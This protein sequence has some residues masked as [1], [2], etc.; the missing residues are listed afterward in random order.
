MREWGLSVFTLR[1]EPPPFIH[2]HG[3]SRC[4]RRRLTCAFAPLRALGRGRGGGDDPRRAAAARA[5]REAPPR[6]GPAGRPHP[7]PGASGR[8]KTEA[9]GEAGARARGG[10]GEDGGSYSSRWVCPPLRRRRE[11]CCVRPGAGGRP[12]GAERSGPGRRGGGGVAGGRGGSRAVG[13]PACGGRGLLLPG[14]HAGGPRGRAAAAGR[15]GGGGG[16]TRPRADPAWAGPAG[17]RAGARRTQWPLEEET[18]EARAPSRLGVHAGRGGPG[19]ETFSRGRE[20]KRLQNKAAAAAAHGAGRGPGGGAPT[21]YLR[22]GGRRGGGGSPRPPNFVRGRTAAGAGARGVAAWAPPPPRVGFVTRVGSPRAGRATSRSAARGAGPGGLGGGVEAPSA[23][24]RPGARRWRAGPARRERRPRRHVPAGRAAR[25]EGGGH[26]GDCAPRPIVPGLGLGPRATG[27]A[28]AEPPPLWAGRGG[29]GGHKGGA[30]RPRPRRARAS[31]PPVAARLPPGNGWGEVAASSRAQLWP[32]APWRPRGEPQGRAPP[33]ATC[34][35]GPGSMSV[36]GTLQSRLFLPPFLFL[37]RSK[38][39]G[40]WR[41]RAGFCSITKKK[42]Q[43]SNMPSGPHQL[44]KQLFI[45]ACSH[46]V[47]I[48]G[49]VVKNSPFAAALRWHR[50]CTAELTIAVDHVRVFQDLFT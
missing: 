2:P 35:A 24:H 20:L 6:G 38:G 22:A 28:V 9:G 13:R 34:A 1:R 19:R 45:P 25:G 32:I 29:A 27:T 10:R 23:A 3:P 47:F 21:R 37:S 36:A 42:T 7:R 39:D 26:G 33:C 41:R 14:S 11:T 5:P 43:I 8:S 17:G 18:R 16:R 48:G 12:G 44:G 40:N 50:S 4:R 49:G 31:A 15:V 30:A 46:E